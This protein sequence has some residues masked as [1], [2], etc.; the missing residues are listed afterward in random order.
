M[1]IPLLLAALLSRWV[2]AGILSAAGLRLIAAGLARQLPAD[3]PLLAAA[4]RA[5]LG[6]LQQA[7]QLLSGH[8]TLLRA[9]YDAAFRQLLNGLAV[10]AVALAALLPYLLRK[11]SAQAS[12]P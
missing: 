3:L 11:D 8:E 4:N 7:T 10:L 9:S 6:D 2:A 12:R 5:A 1:L